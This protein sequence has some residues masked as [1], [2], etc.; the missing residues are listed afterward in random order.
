MQHLAVEV[1][2]HIECSES[3]APGQRVTHE[4]HGPD[5]VWMPGNIKRHPLALWQTAL[6]GLSQVELHR[7]VYLIDPLRIPVRSLLA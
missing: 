3:F 4:V 1:I 6:G 5:G 7:L 2:E